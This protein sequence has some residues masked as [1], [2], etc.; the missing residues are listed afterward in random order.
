MN[1]PRK[2]SLLSQRKVADIR[3]PQSNDP[4][5][6]VSWSTKQ[7]SKQKVVI[8]TAFGMEGC[9]MIDMYSRC[10]S[11]VSVAYIDTG[12]FFP[13]TRQLIN[14]MSEKYPQVEFKKWESHISVKKQAIQFGDRLWREDPN[15]CCKIRKVAPM[16]QNL[17]GYD[18]WVTGI[19]RTQ[20]QQRSDTKLLSWNPQYEVLKFC[21]LVDWNRED[22]W[23]YIQKHEVPF[24]QLHQQGFPSIGCFHC[25]KAVPNSRPTDDARS[26]RWQGHNKT[27][28]GLHYSD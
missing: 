9:A 6:L 19:R 1:L 17:Q 12:F 24:N 14:K 25:T 26:G 18:V 16:T 2:R 4:L 23:N 8:T 10:S 21:P 11:S 15:L 22:V 13:E 27:E 5:E 28:C 3:V 7:F 20:T